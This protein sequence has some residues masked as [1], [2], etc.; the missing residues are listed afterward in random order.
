MKVCMKQRYVIEFLYVKKMDGD[1][2]VG[3]GTERQWVL[4]FSCGDSWSLLLV[5]VL[6]STACRLL[7]IAGGIA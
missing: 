4:H 7:F 5:K 1:Q 6:T 2:A 3:V